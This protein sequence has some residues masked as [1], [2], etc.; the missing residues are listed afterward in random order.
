VPSLLSMC[1]ECL[2]TTKLLP[3]STMLLPLG[4]PDLGSFVPCKCNVVHCSFIGHYMFRSNWS[5]SGVQVVV[6]KDS[7]FG[8]VGCRWLLLVLFGSLVVA[9]LSVLAGAGV[10]LCAG[11]PL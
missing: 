10:L 8:Y 3:L 11:R 6:V 5:S 1:N 7:I 4:R 2:S 9:A